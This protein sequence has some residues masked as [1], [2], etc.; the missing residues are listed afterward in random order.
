VVQIFRVKDFALHRTLV[1]HE[2][3]DVCCSRDLEGKDSYGMA[4]GVERED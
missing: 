4:W 1:L 3:D 2:I